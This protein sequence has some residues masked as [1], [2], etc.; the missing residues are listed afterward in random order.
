[1]HFKELSIHVYK[2]KINSGT[3]N[4]KIYIGCSIFPIFLSNICKDTFEYLC[5]GQSIYECVSPYLLTDFIWQSSKSTCR[6]VKARGMRTLKKKL[7]DADIFLKNLL[8]NN[9]FS[10]TWWKKNNEK[11]S[12]HTLHKWEVYD[13]W[14]DPG[15]EFKI[16][17]TLGKR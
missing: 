1:M 13:W 14:N 12:Y 10:D 17:F 5:M 15:K 9:F 2:K 4:K 3:S 7:G 8:Q 6:M 11:N 16:F